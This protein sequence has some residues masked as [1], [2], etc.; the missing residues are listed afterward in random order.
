MTSFQ[1]KDDSRPRTIN[2]GKTGGNGLHDISIGINISVSRLVDID[3]SAFVCY[4]DG[5]SE[6][7]FY[8][9]HEA[10]DGNVSVSGDSLSDNDTFDHSVFVTAHKLPANVERI[11]IVATTAGASRTRWQYLNAVRQIEVAVQNGRSQYLAHV[12][13]DRGT[14]RRS[15]VILGELY[16]QDGQ[17]VFAASGKTLVGGLAKLCKRFGITTE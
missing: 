16:R 12:F 8:H 10:A 17:W 5:H 9:Q 6:L 2:L 3:V 1:M 11:V 13:Y 15:A 4:G 14:P 7:A